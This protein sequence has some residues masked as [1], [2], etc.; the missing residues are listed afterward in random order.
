MAVAL[1][2][3][4]AQAQGVTR[5]DVAPLNGVPINVQRH[6]LGSGE[7]GQ[8]G[9]ELSNPVLQNNIFHGPQYM[10]HF[11]TAATIWPRVI[12]VNCTVD[13]KCEGYNWA[14][15]MGRAEYLFVTPRMVVPPKPVIVEKIVEKIVVVPGPERIILKEVPIKKLKE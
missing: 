10:P 6:A 2:A 13:R 5:N 1:M 3:T 15:S 4:A 11:P 12:E 9:F 8:R 7:P 14:P